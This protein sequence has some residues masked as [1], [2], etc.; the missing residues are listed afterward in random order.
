M[1]DSWPPTK[2]HPVCIALTSWGWNLSPRG[3]PSVDP[4]AMSGLGRFL[5]HMTGREV[6]GEAGISPQGKSPWVL[7]LFFIG[8]CVGSPHQTS[9]KNTKPD[10]IWWLNLLCCKLLLPCDPLLPF[11]QSYSLVVSKVIE[12]DKSISSH[13]LKCTQIANLYVNTPSFKRRKKD[14]Y[15]SRTPLKPPMAKWFRRQETLL[16]HFLFPSLTFQIN[17]AIPLPE[18]YYCNWGFNLPP[19]F[20][21]PPKKSSRFPQKPPFT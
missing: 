19:M 15:L 17:K 18:S 3:V 16:N 4:H 10:P 7:Q 14:L 1:R 13:E 5:V 21:P 9:H 8:Y 2:T 11:P 12:K 20:P 6:F